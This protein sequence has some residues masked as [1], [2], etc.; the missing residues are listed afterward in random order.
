MFMHCSYQKYSSKQERRAF[1][2]LVERENKLQ[3]TKYIIKSQRVINAM[4]N[5]LRKCNTE[6]KEIGN[7][8]WGPSEKASL[9]NWPQ[10]RSWKKWEQIMWIAG[11]LLRPWSRKKLSAL[12]EKV[13]TP[14][15]IK[16]I[17][18]WLFFPHGMRCFI[19]Y[20]HLWFPWPRIVIG[21]A[22]LLYKS[23]D[24]EVW[25]GR[26]GFLHLNDIC[27]VCCSGGA[28]ESHY[29]WPWEVTGENKVG[30]WHEIYV[31]EGLL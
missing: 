26:G 16:T 13:K 8:E 17:S 14:L 27:L 28:I 29:P 30:G 20:M 4:K 1:S 3:M 11:R 9:R 24:L 10:R 12:V 31:L 25:S 18:I 15:R 5:K 22:L 19:G 21:L 23:G 2:F 7:I 6:H